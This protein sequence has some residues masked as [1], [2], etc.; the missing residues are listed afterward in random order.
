MTVEATQSTGWKVGTFTATATDIVG[1]VTLTYSKSV[2]TVLPFGTTT[3][4]VTAKDRAG[5]H[6]SAT[7]T[8]LVQDLTPPVITA[9]DVTVEATSAAGAKVFFSPSVSDAVG[10]GTVTTSVASGTTF[11]IGVH[12]VSVTATDG[13]GNLSTTTFQVTVQDTTAP[14][15]TVGPNVVVEATSSAG[16]TVTYPA[17]SATDAVSGVTISYSPPPPGGVFPIGVTT[18]V[19]TATDA[20]GNHSSKSFTVTVRDTT[21]PVI[22]AV[23]GNVTTEG[24]TLGGAIVTYT[25]TP[26]ATDAVG[27]VTFSYSKA[28]GSVFSVGTTTVTLTATDGVGN[29]SS[30][31]FTVTVK[32]TTAPVIA[33]SDM[34]VEATQSSGWKVGTFTESA[35]DIV[36]PVTLT[37]S[38]SAGTVLPFGTTTV[39]VTATDAAGNHSSATFTVTVRDTTAP[40]ITAPDLIV[41]AT[42][43][44]GAKV[45]YTPSVSDA[46]GGGTVT[47]SVASG[48][49]FSIGVHTVSVTATDGHGNLSTTTFQV[50]VQDTTAPVINAPLYLVVN[51]TSLAGAIVTYPAF[52][53]D[54]VGPIT[55]TYSIPS[56]SLFPL[57]FSPLITFTATDAYGH[58]STGS[59]TVFVHDVTPP[60]ITSVSGNLTV[61]G[62][63]TGGAIV[64]YAAATATDPIVPVQITYSKP[65]GSFF[66]VGTTTV[67]VTATD[68]MGNVTKKTFKVTVID[69]TPPVITS[70][71]P[72]LT[73]EATSSYGAAVT[74]V[75]AIA[76]DIVGP[77]TISYSK[78]SGSTF[79]LGTT[80]VTVTAKDAAGNIA[81]RTFTITVVDTT[82]PVIT[83]SN[84]VVEATGPS[85]A[86]VAHYDASATDAVSGVTLTYSIAPNSTFALG[87]T[88]VTVTATD[89]HG[90]V[91][92]K[93][94]T[95]TVRDTTPPVITSIS[96]NITV[97]RT[98]SAGAIV[99]FPAATATDVAGPVTI[100]YTTPSGPVSRSGT[101]FAVGTTTVTVTAT[102]AA[103]N[104]T[105]R[106]FKVTVT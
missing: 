34:T 49:T 54:A 104:V 9:P 11:S 47:T 55:Y 96:G 43:A 53:T 58:T 69:T 59:F 57:S 12:T 14:V 102:D 88:T 42:S 21:A 64:T 77:V 105:K 30:K 81:T 27:G 28:S 72:N 51:A 60:V 82:P 106:T 79:A 98:S 1:P 99:T 103:G 33:P 8:V 41:E 17:V 45:Y 46:V 31:T 62:N 70:V 86:K 78:S 26:A 36:G 83:A 84:M 39:T 73:I 29:H 38:K 76:T 37:Y 85:G 40:V 87:P 24:N 5:N 4:T 97:A 56:G 94:F 10:G 44:A 19:V 91:S 66:A 100:T 7:F 95:I 23:N 93:S 74:Y 68:E 89:S 101:L 61:E 2:G 15:L 65:S 67:W 50:T 35:T 6:S 13:H 92:V 25:V 32:D 18:V 75:P 80:T 3:V 90:N 20:A 63:T 52:A 48:T 71:S 16:A 22:T